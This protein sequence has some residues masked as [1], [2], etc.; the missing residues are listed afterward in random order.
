MGRAEE[1]GSTGIERV[2]GYPSVNPVGAGAIMSALLWLTYVG[3]LLAQP[4]RFLPPTD[5]CGDA[6]EKV[7]VTLIVILATDKNQKVDPKLGAIAQAVKKLDTS[8]TGFR[9]G[10]TTCETMTVGTKKKF[11]LVEEQEALVEAKHCDADPKRVCLKVKVPAMG[12]ITYTSCCG[13]FFPFLTGYRTK[14]R[15]RVIIAVMVESCKDEE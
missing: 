2:Q 15:E 10:T 9:L 6:E 14:A 5:P 1:S 4:V 12:S 7:N 8:L 11:P 3:L 13:K